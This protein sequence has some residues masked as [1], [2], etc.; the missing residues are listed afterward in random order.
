MVKR[1]AT[2]ATVKDATAAEH[3]LRRGLALALQ[4]LSNGRCELQDAAARFAAL[5]DDQGSLLAAAALVLFIGIAD[6]DYDGFEVAVER[7]ITLTA[8]G[9]HAALI[10]PMSEIAEPADKL[11]VQAGAVVAGSFAALDAPSLAARATTLAQAL[12]QPDIPAPLRCCAGLAALNYHRISMDLPAV[13]WLEL[14]MRPLLADPAVSASL[15]GEACHLFVQ[16]LYECE[17]PQQAVVMRERWLASVAAGRP[18]L[19]VIELKFLLLDAQMAL[20]VGGAGQAEVGRDAL[21]RAEPLLNPRAPRPAGW[22]HLLTSRLNLMQGQHR[23]ALTHARLALRLMT[24]SHVPERWMGL[25]VMQEGQVQM[26]VGAY[27]EA[28]PFFERAGREASGSQAD[29]CHCLAQLAQALQHLVV[30]QSASDLN[31]GLIHLARGLK[32]ARELAWL[33]FFRPSPH[34][35]AAIC[36]AALEHG[37]EATFAREVIQQRGLPVARPDLV[38]WP[39]PIRVRSLGALRIELNSQALNFKGKVAK[40]PLE[41]LMFVV[42]SSGSDVSVAT[43]AFALWRELDGDKARAALNIALHRLRKLLGSDDGVLLAHG[44]L[45]LNPHTVWVDCLAFEQLADSAGL[46]TQPLLALPVRAAAQRAVALYT[47]PF[48]GDS[49]DEAWQMVYRSRLASKFKR[50]VTLLA[51][52]AIARGDH[53][54]ARAVLD[55]G[56]ECDPLAEDL[57]RMRAQISAQIKLGG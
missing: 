8:T 57:V 11:L 55:R 28:V 6:D 48:L 23:N 5:G 14:A 53:A 2:E 19:P 24:E 26:A 39:W 3:A 22:W 29:F 52:D 12:A 54:S 16:S 10:D 7:V 15:V 40:K 47:G 51:R 1:I 33:N 49:E 25:I 30:A 50:M 35:A 42:A 17:A 20:G 46:P 45:S 21:A 32:L 27:A 36:A 37:I 34:V 43:V 44:R 18:T 4:D 9:A 41:L 31:P 38:E 56:L 13:M